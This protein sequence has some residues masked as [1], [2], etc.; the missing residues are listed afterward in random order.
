MTYL[1]AALPQLAPHH[2]RI[3]TPHGAWYDT[4]RNMWG[5]APLS[6]TYA[7]PQMLSTA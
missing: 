7:A 5:T 3:E 2:N 1:P 6:A 4:I